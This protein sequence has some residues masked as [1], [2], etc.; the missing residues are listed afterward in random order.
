VNTRQRFLETLRYGHPDRFPYLDYTVRPDVLALWERQGL[1][2]GSDLRQLF[3]LERWD[4]V[5]THGDIELDLRAMP[6]FEG[7][8]RSRADWDRLKSSFDPGTP[9]RYPHDWVHHVEEWRDR[10]YPLGLIVW[11]GIL[12]PLQ[13]GEWDTLA[14]LLYLFYDDPALVHEMVAA[15]TDFSLALLERALAEVEWDFAV[16]EEPIASNHAPVI[17]P[18]H[19]RRICLPHI[20]RVAR[21]VRAAGIDLLVADSQGAVG[22]LIPVWREAGLNTLW[23]GDVGASGLD[24]RALR[25]TFGHELRL[26]G[27][28]DLRVM[29]CDCDAVERQVMDVAAPLLAEGGY[30][31]LLDGRVRRGVPYGNYVHYRQLLAG[32]AEHQAAR[33]RNA[34]AEHKAE[35]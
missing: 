21:R 25:R 17:S 18:R 3:G 15:V 14:D 22:P 24:Y 13:V 1:A 6:P 32:L 10:D 9:G 34:T 33:S 16:F 8:L 23:L 26:I 12:L 11:R 29:S 30:I 4:L 2:P 27:G 35:A 7:R 5:G 19:Y 31:P 28:L 20:E